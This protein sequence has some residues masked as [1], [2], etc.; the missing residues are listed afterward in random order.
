M[1]C[2]G[3]R[4]VSTLFTNN[5]ASQN[6]T[7]IAVQSGH[8][9]TG[10]AGVLT[11]AGQIVQVVQNH[12]PGFVGTS[13]SDVLST[14][15]TSYVDFLVKAITTKLANSQIYIKTY[16]MYYG[17]AMYGDGRVLRDNL[18]I[19][20]CKYQIYTGNNNDFHS[21]GFQ[22]VDSPSKAAGTTITYK[23]QIK[24]NSGAALSL[25]YADSGG[26]VNTNMILMEI[27][28]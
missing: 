9:I 14:T 26:K 5:I 20:A 4:T 17:N 1:Y 15:S 8:T 3:D 18:E 2:I 13:G 21:F 11:E 27:A 16:S 23:Q 28:V 25:G 24:Y 6:G 7:S 22:L 12:I 10:D 19:D